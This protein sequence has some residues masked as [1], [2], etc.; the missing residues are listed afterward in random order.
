MHGIRKGGSRLVRSRASTF[1][2]RSATREER[3]PAVLFAGSS[4]CLVLP[5]VA[6]FVDKWWT[7]EAVAAYRPVGTRAW[8][9]S[10]QFRTKTR[11][12]VPPAT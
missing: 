4:C 11:P 5:S 6:W 1:S 12:S 3:R 8:S 9:S 7:S 2:K 10:N